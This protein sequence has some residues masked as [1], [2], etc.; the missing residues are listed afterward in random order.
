METEKIIKSSQEQAFAA[1]VGYLNQIR[2]DRLAEALSK[3]NLNFAAAMDSIET[4]FAKIKTDIISRNRGGDM[5]IHGF[6]A[7]I[8]EC[9]IGNARQQI[10]GKVGEYVWVNDNGPVDILWGVDKI[11]QKFVQSGGHLSLRAISEH[12]HRYPDFLADGGKY[13]IPK[14]HYDKI[15][16]YLAM[17]EATANKLPTSAGEFSLRQWWEVHNFFA[18]NNIEVSKLEPAILEYGDV[19]R[20]AISATFE[21]ERKNLQQIDKEQRNAAYQDSKPTLAEGAKAA[22]VGAAVE[23]LSVFVLAIVRKC[24]AGK[25]IKAFNKADWLEIA[26][27]TGKGNL[28]GWVRGTSIYLLTN[29][30]ATPAAVASAFTTAAFGVAEQAHLLRKQAINEQQFL[31]NAEILCLEAAVSGLSSFA[32]Q[33]I[34]PIPVLGAVVGNAVGTM[35]YQ[36]GKDNL[37]AREKELIKEYIKELADLDAGLAAEY[38]KYIERLNVLYAEYLELLAAAFDPDITRALEGSVALAAYVG[39]PSEE[40]LDSHDKIVSYF[41]N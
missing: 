1:W 37:S 6:I 24:R 5:G 23:G 36:I 14:D 7:E 18:S 28:R 41:M 3:Q 26:E 25:Q 40:I 2:L 38:Q 21:Q 22:A 27:E 29:Y 35:I 30:T 33:V 34:I 32:G 16:A 10:V 11:Q 12:L 13:Q 39:V 17:P 15:M 8:A 19:Q 9:G 20:D 4:A 31:E